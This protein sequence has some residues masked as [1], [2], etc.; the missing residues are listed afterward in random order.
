LQTLNYRIK[1]SNNKEKVIE[2]PNLDLIQIFKEISETALL[3]T[4]AII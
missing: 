2:K 3:S 1:K 4:T